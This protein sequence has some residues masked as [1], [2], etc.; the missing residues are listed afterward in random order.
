LH[1]NN[2]S[3]SAFF[4]KVAATKSLIWTGMAKTRFRA[5]ARLRSAFKAS[6]RSFRRGHARAYREIEIGCQ[7]ILYW[8]RQHRKKLNAGLLALAIIL[9]VITYRT[10]S[11]RIEEFFGSPDLFT[12]LRT[13]FATLGGARIGA[14]AIGF[15]V[16]MLAVQLNFARIPHG[17]FRRVSSDFRLIGAFTVTFVLAGFVTTFS[18]LP[19]KSWAALALIVTAYFV[20]AVL[21]LFIYAYRR[22]LALIN[23]L[24]QLNLVYKEAD[25]DLERWKRR[26]Q[27]LAPLVEQKT[28]ERNFG[29]THD[30]TRLLFFQ[31]NPHWTDITRRAVTYAVGF[32][33][34][35]SEENDYTVA[36]AALQTVVGLNAK[37][38]EAKG[39]TFFASNPLSNTQRV[40]DPFITDTLEHL[41]LLTQSALSRRDEDQMRQIFATFAN[42]VGV[43]ST[44]NYSRKSEISKHDATLAAGY[45]A[46]AVE[47]VAPHNLPDV[48]MEGIRQMGRAAAIV[49]TS[50]PTDATMSIQKIAQFSATGAM[51]DNYR[52]ATLTGMDQLTK[53]T[54]QLILSTAHDIGY[55][56][57]ELRSAI[58]QV[59][60]IV[61]TLVTDERFASPHS[62]YLAPYYSLTQTDTFGEWITQVANELR[63]ADKDNKNVQRIIRHVKEWSD[64]LYQPTKAVLLLAIEK[65]TQFAFDSIHWIE[66]VTKALA[67]ISQAPA[68]DC[69]T[70]KEIE[71]NAIRLLSALSWIPDDHE[72]VDF[73]ENYGV[74]EELFDVATEADGLGASQ[75]AATARKI[76]LDWSIKLGVGRPHQFEEALRGVSLS[77]F[78]GDE[79]ANVAWLKAEVPK[80]LAK[81][82]VDQSTLDDVARRLRA[83]AASFRPN[84]YAT[85][86]IDDAMQRVDTTKMQ[87]LLV[88][89]ANIISPATASEKVKLI[90]SKFIF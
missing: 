46:S 88:E 7:T 57:K 84:E 11:G 90:T 36:G 49:M 62:T 37:Y 19:D 30:A 29:S 85:S 59:T 33:R 27:R 86:R 83:K 48:L 12:A 24:V 8:A 43:Y 73:A 61:L 76:L 21:L 26:A 20:A 82:P 39:R 16:V 60:K 66:Q 28:P 51:K 74:T 65:R 52:P 41:R 1:R 81:K 2:A 25:R 35:F 6:R 55:A 70:A 15:S 5:K 71:E 80:A 23:P 69:H 44:I 32:A 75:V 89:I 13:L 14:T 54:Q 53:L 56:V 31:A 17:L 68:A 78:Y 50:S 10:F 9:G 79:T 64:G 22:A 38:V 4:R 40:R 77:T 18:V 45:L 67:Q 42:L 58:E 34:R 63:T 47:S 3:P 87:N 72:T